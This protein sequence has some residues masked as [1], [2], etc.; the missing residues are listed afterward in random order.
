MPTHLDL[1]VRLLVA[2]GLCGLLGVEREITEQ[3][4]GFRTHI[5]VGLG[6][7]LFT[8]VSAYG[9]QA[10]LY[11]PAMRAQV[12]V[13]RVASQV[14]VGIGFLGGGAILKYGTSIRG[15]TT[16]AGLWMSAAVGTA[17]GLGMSALAAETTA[18]ALLTLTV[19][20][21][22]R[23]LLRRFAVG[24]EEFTIEAEPG[25][26]LSSLVQAVRDARATF[27]DLQVS[28]EG[29]VQSIKLVVRMGA[30]AIPANLAAELAR[31]PH[32]RSVDWTGA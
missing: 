23:R 27:L 20:R 15:L 19:L 7:A 3:P 12:D 16:A 17:A 31:H 22:A 32:V 4:A 9:F 8:V 21:P 14:V 30:G 5:V 18:I 25:V 6:A 2:A 13:S 24:R 29:E 26:D 11:D 1:F 10:V 28:G